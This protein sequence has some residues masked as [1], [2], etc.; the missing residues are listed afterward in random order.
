MKIFFNLFIAHLKDMFRDKTVA[1]WFFLFP[2]LFVF[3]YGIIFSNVGSNNNFKVAI[4]APPQSSAAQVFEHIPVFTITHTDRETAL[5]SVKANKNEAAVIVEKAEN[6]SEKVT[7]YYITNQ[8][9]SG[10]IVAGLIK[11]VLT[12]AEMQYSGVKRHYEVV[13]KIANDDS[14]RMI[15]YIIPGILAMAIMQLGLFGSMQFVTYREKKITKRL[16]LAPISKASFLGSEISLRML[17]S[18][19]QGLIILTV[20][21]FVFKVP[22]NGSLLG[23]TGIILLGAATFISLGYLVC[24]FAHTA[25]AAQ[26]LVQAVQF[27]MMFLSG[28]FFPTKLLPTF[29]QPIVKIMPLTY[30]GDGLRQIVLGGVGDFSMA[31]NMTILSGWLVITFILTVKFFRWE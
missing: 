27:P 1:F 6:G 31:T 14:L 17:M 8:D 21:H 19:L 28:V 3:L 24:S 15:D 16:A 18:L 11:Q 7:V 29:I 20:G 4:Y 5:E 22:I 13:E 10:A 12:E 26:G 2:L 30:L 23:L 9:S 25:E